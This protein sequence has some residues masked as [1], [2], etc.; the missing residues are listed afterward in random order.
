MSFTTRC[1]IRKNTKELRDRLKEIG[2]TICPCCYFQGAVWLDTLPET[3]SAHGV[4]Y[5]SEDSPFKSQE[6]ELS[7]Y[8]EECN[9]IDCGENDDLFLSIAALRDDSGAFQWFS[10]GVHRMKAKRIPSRYMVTNCGKMSAKDLVEMFKER[11][12]VKS[13]IMTQL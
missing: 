11:D 1:Y 7:V 6:E 8:V 5:H 10:D 2:Y 9:G 12:K 4:G 3:S 13:D